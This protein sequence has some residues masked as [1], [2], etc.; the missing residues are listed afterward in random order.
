MANPPSYDVGKFGD[1]SKPRR[2]TYSNERRSEKVPRGVAERFVDLQGNV[3]TCQLVGPGIPKT[4]DAVARGR[5]ELHTRKNADGTVVGYVEH[6]KC[7]LRHGVQFRNKVIEEEF[8]GLPENLKRPCEQ[9]P[10]P[11][12]SM[13]DAAGVIIKHGDACPHVEWIIAA[14][15]K[16]ES[17]R[18]ASRLATRESVLD[19][20]RKKLAAAERA[21]EEQRKT[22]ERM[23]ELMSAKQQAR[24]RAPE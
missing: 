24:G 11:S 8:A 15:R 7:P 13:R 19:I 17:D 21:A 9:D 18:I 23:L 20:E 14:R 10:N 22:N 1:P 12:Q 4:N 2:V 3:V 5:T 6:N 16:K